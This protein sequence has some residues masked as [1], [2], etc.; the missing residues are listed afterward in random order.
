[1]RRLWLV[2]CLLVGCTLGPN[3]RVYLAVDRVESV[4]P[5]LLVTGWAFHCDGRPVTDLAVYSHTTGQRIYG[6]P[7][8]GLPRPD[9]QQQFAGRC[10]VPLRS[11]FEL[12]LPPVARQSFP[13]Q[14]QADHAPIDIGSGPAGQ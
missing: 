12:R 1:M 6:Q 2:G 11:G 10:T 13:L 8:F 7:R 3:P 9:V 5:D 4:G 14:V